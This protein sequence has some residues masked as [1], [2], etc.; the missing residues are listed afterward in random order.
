MHLAL[1]YRLGHR[2]LPPTPDIWLSTP[3]PHPRYHGKH[4]PTQRCPSNPAHKHRN[5]RLSSITNHDAPIPQGCGTTAARNLYL[6]N[7]KMR[8]T[9]HLSDTKHE[10][11]RYNQRRIQLRIWRQPPPVPATTKAARRR[12]IWRDTVILQRPLEE[13]PCT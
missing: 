11:Y 9:R 3:H 13:L 7:H 4:A 2:P 8:Q 10:F 12:I 6:A 5:M 1:S